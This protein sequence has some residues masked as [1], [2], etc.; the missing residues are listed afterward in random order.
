MDLFRKVK[1][2]MQ[3]VSNGC[4]KVISMG[5]QIKLIG[6]LFKPADQLV[7]KIESGYRMECPI[8]CNAVIYGMMSNCWDIDLMER[9]NFKEICKLLAKFFFGT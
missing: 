2:G 9:P 7:D 4:L 6:F 8:G 1:I 5:V 3:V